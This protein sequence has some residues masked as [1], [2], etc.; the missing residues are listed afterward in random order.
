M[1]IIPIKEGE[2]IERALKKY[3][4]KFEKTKVMLQLRGRKE[5]EKPSI[6]KRQ[7]II[8]ASYKQRMQS[9]EA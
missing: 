6:T 9:L 7:Q 3:K 1:L 8:R 5:F 4:K 2:N